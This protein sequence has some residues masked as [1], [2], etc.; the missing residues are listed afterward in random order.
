MTRSRVI[1]LSGLAVLLAA[2]YP[3]SRAWAAWEESQRRAWIAQAVAAIEAGAEALPPLPWGVDLTEPGGIEEDDPNLRRLLSLL[4]LGARPPGYQHQLMLIAAEENRKAAALTA[5]ARTR[6]PPARS[7][8]PG[9][10]AVTPTPG[11]AL[12]WSSLGPAGAR[13]QFNGTYYQGQDSGRP[14]AIRVDPTDEN[15]VYVAVSGGGVWKTTDF[16][17]GAPAWTPLTDTLGNLAIGAMDIDPNNHLTLYVGTGD[18]FDTKGGSVVK[19]VDG[20]ATWSTPVLLSAPAP[21]GVTV[22]ATSIRSIAVDPNNSQIVLAATDV[23]LFRSIDGGATFGLIDLPNNATYGA[24]DLETVWDVVYLGT[25][26]GQSV[27]AVSGIWACPGFFAPQAG[28]AAGACPGGGPSTGNV[29]DVWRSVDSGASWTSSRAAG[30]LPTQAGNWGATPDTT[31]LGEIGR[32]ALGAAPNA[33]PSLATIYAQAGNTNEAASRNILLFKSTDGGQTWVKLATPLSTNLT[34]PTIGSACTTL[35]LGHGQSWYNLAVGV[36]PGNPNRAIMGG[37]LCAARTIDGGA[38]WQL[39][40]HW[41]PSS[42]TGDTAD[43]AGPLPYAHADWHTIT[44][45]RVGGRFAI[46][47]GNDGGIFVSYNA[48][49]L[50]PTQLVSWLEPDIGLTTH[51]AYSLG[52]GDPVFGNA[53]VLYTGLQDNGTRW[54]IS[55]NELID[56]IN[57]KNFDQV[58]GGDGVGDAVAT[59]PLG[60]NQVY[61]A[62]VPGSRRFCQPIG[63]DCGSATRIINGNELVNWRAISLAPVAGDGEPFI[64]RYSAVQD[65]QASVISATTFNVYKLRVDANDNAFAQRLTPTGIVAGGAARSIQNQCV[66]ASPWTYTVGGVPTRIYGVV[67]TGGNFATLADTGT[68]TPTLTPTTLG[69]RVGTELITGSS[70]IAFPRDPAHLGGTDIRQTFVA[71]SLA[72]VNSTGANIT[73][74]TGHIFKT[75]DG[76]ATWVPIHG[77]GTGFDLPNIPILVVRFDPSDPTDQRMYVGTDLGLYRTTDQGQTWARYGN[78]PSVR[79]TDISVARNGSLIRVS[80]YGR[81]LWEIYPHSEA[82]AAPGNG[83]WDQSGLVDFQDVLA[84]ASRIGS[85]PPP[86]NFT[87][88]IPPVP[89]YDSTLDLTGGATTI[90]EADLTALLAK[91]GGAP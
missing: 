66:H 86:P 38:T 6:P 28:G 75:I 51:L 40:A 8:R 48:F 32:I 49:D 78:L 30:T 85:A 70:S 9:D 79:V 3:L 24:T 7:I 77:N 62:S 16:H 17:T 64:E 36:D 80:T 63:K 83:D 31:G 25:S 89:V 22:T 35:D 88:P 72:V 82:A 57:L 91:F 87:P 23:G 44:V 27:W 12:N 42:G 33:N 46:L 34:N 73:P 68:G 50:T 13:I 5:R 29:G 69:L 52:S 53:Q 1:A 61:W 10:P 19:S 76:G 41:I 56:I 20:G 84:L 67:L 37:N 2:I 4:A 15:T 74:A 90:E 59:D 39:V 14:T 71:T 54:R 81:G 26:A 60:Q 11:T 21:V 18:A 47:V 58:I 43:G 45:T 65:A 55:E